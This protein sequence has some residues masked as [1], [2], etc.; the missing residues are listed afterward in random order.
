MRAVSSADLQDLWLERRPRADAAG[1][2]PPAVVRGASAAERR[3]GRARQGRARRKRP[4]VA[5]APV[6][7]LAQ[8]QTPNA[9]G[10]NAVEQRAGDQGRGS[11]VSSRVSRTTR[12]HTAGE[13]R[14]RGSRLPRSPPGRSSVVSG[15][16]KEARIGPR[17]AARTAVMRS[18][19]SPP[20]SSATASSLARQAS[21]GYRR[22]EPRAAGQLELAFGP[23]GAGDPL[24]IGEGSSRPS[25][26]S[27]ADV[28]PPSASR[29]PPRCCA[30][31][32]DARQPG[33]TVRQSLG[34]RGIL[35]CRSRSRASRRLEQVGVAARRGLRRRSGAAIARGG[36]AWP[37]VGGLQKQWGQAR[38]ERQVGRRAAVRGEKGH[39]R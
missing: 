28:P 12:R 5:A 30:T 32:E 17:P 27:S 13:G 39:T 19:R 24:R 8:G 35:R 22:K 37:V 14:W 1:P 36:A 10:A 23:T 20:P 15:A 29:K 11:G 21:G 16:A 33:P 31:G 4:G 26:R 7:G 2:G 9:L 25:E 6:A 38:R 3:R 18:S 34:V